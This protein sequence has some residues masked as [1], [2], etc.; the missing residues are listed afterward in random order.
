MLA[1]RR[2]MYKSTGMFMFLAL[3]C[4]V[5]PSCFQLCALAFFV[6]PLSLRAGTAE[7][8]AG[9]DVRR[10]HDRL[11][12]IRSKGA[13]ALKATPPRSVPPSVVVRTKMSNVLIVYLTNR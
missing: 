5:T 10:H 2:S 13:T 6:P 1:S 11:R 8:Y 7:I 4:L 12:S 3:C 9:T